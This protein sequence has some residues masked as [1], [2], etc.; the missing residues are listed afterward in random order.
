MRLLAIDTTVNYLS[1]ALYDETLTYGFTRLSQRTQSRDLAPA[2]RDTLAATG[3]PPSSLEGVACTTGPGSYTGIRIGLS[4]AKGVAAST[5]CPLVGFSTLEVFAFGHA[6]CDG[7]IIS[8]MQVSP[9][10]FAW[11]HFRGGETWQRLTEDSLWSTEGL[12]A[13]LPSDALLCGPGAQDLAVLQPELGKRIPPGN[14]LRPAPQAVDMLALAIR[15]F[16]DSGEDQL[17]TVSPN[18]L[19]ASAPEE[20]FRRLEA[21]P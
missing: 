5:P 14:G 11:A 18:Y 10:T 16:E 6:G 19:R 9:G 8:V 7:T 15:H 1:V 20:R 2:V 3:T 13:A 17:E 21:V 12:E 4:F